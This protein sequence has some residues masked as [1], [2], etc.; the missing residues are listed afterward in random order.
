MISVIVDARGGDMELPTLLSAL[1]AAAVDG[2]VGDVVIAVAGE[3]PMTDALRDETGAEIFV[4]DLAGA[5][6]LARNSRVLALPAGIRLRRDWIAGVTDH[7]ARGGGE[8]VLRGESAGWLKAGTCGVL[9]SKDRA[10]NL[11]HAD[12]KRLRGQLGVRAP[13]IG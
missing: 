1:T 3:T 5:A 12:L 13:R 10:A 9:T 11:L 8:A 2:L 7:L 4:G 6:A